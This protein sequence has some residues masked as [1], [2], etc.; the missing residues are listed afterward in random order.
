MKPTTTPCSSDSGAAL[1][2]AVLTIPILLVFT[3]AM[4]D[5]GNWFLQHYALSRVVYEGARAGAS[6]GD[7]K[8]ATTS[9]P[10]WDASKATMNCISEPINS[11]M[12][13]TLTFN[14]EG[15]FIM[16]SRMQTLVQ[17]QLNASNSVS[18]S[19]GTMW[20]CFNSD[21]KIVQT[22]I[23]VPFQSFLGNLFNVNGWIYRTDMWPDVTA[24]ATAPYLFS[25]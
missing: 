4:L 14:E 18:V 10:H 1:I 5:M 23:T 20:T 16:M 19:Q 7:M 15:H 13:N 12:S 2:E 17:R 6:L 21:L 3:F 11:A 22:E 8:Q 25:S 9:L 24:R